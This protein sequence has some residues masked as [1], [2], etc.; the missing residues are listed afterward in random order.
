MTLEELNAKL[1]LEYEDLVVQGLK[2]SIEHDENEHVYFLEHAYEFA[3]YQ[4]VK[5]FFENMTEEEYNENWKDLIEANEGINLLQ[6]I[7]QDWLNYET[8]WL[9]F[10]NPQDLETI[11]RSY[12]KI[13]KSTYNPQK[14]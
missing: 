4:E 11:I 12:L 8:E 7:F 10:F 2:W 6:G 9:N 14:R 5:Y 3:H 13:P 1:D